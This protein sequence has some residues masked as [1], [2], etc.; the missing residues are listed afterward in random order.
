[1][2]IDNNNSNNNNDYNNDNNKNSSNSNNNYSN[3]DY[4]NNNNNSN[5]KNL[6]SATFHKQISS[7][8]YITRNKTYPE[9][10]KFIMISQNLQN[11]IIKIIKIT[12]DQYPQLTL[13][14]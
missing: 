1:M 3:N 9:R 4:D 12:L 10:H 5:I 11:K 6:H 13:D 8:L 14:G 7:T 2:L